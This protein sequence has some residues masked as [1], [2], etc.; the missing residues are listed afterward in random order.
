MEAVPRD[1]EASVRM[2]PLFLD[3]GAH[4]LYTREVMKKAPVGRRQLFDP[5][6]FYE[7]KPF[8]DYVDAYA[9]FLKANKEHC[10]VYAN[11]DVIFNPKLS[12][13]VLKYLENEHGLSPVPVI[14]F[15]TKLKWIERHLND[16][17]SYIGIG[18]LGQEA[19]K[20]HYVSWADGVFHL[21]CSGPSK[22]P[23]VKTH[24]FAIG[25]PSLM[26]RYPWWSVDTASWVKSAGFG[27]IFFPT[28]R[29]GKWDF[30][31]HMSILVSNKSPGMSIRGM[32]ICNI[33]KFERDMV[34]EWLGEL[35]LSLGDLG[36]SD[37][38]QTAMNHRTARIRAN[39]F[40]YRG[41][42]RCLP[43]PRPFDVPISKRGFWQ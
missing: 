29:N 18:G 15:G 21:L 27:K 43:W 5:Y 26:K 7:T 1:N 33:A 2:W 32:H 41:L 38:A 30:F 25:S 36:D 42:A 16:G 24:G 4:S 31:K 8:W 19:Q 20:K 12:W 13:K 9:S 35:Q 23:V 22:T 28:K 3:S 40:F 11:V 6:A 34:K 37:D 10:K 39:L 14:H 17:Y